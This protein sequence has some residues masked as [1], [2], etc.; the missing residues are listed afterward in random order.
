V[1][2]AL[3]RT[4]KAITATAHQVARLLGTMLKHDTACVRQK[5]AV[6]EQQY[7]NRMV[8]NLTRRAKAFGYVL[9][10]TPEGTLA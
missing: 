8:Q 10:K 2:G 9:V 3:Q 7:C 1:R 5:L 4:P 6:Y